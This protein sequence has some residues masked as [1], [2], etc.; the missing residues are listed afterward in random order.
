MAG[1]VESFHVGWGEERTPTFTGFGLFLL[2]F[3]SSPE[4]AALT[5]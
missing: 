5:S 4:P 1:D 3:T 2:G